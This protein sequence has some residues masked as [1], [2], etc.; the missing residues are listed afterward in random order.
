[1]EANVA[2]AVLPLSTFRIGGGDPEQRLAVAPACHVGVV[3]FEFESEK[4][5]QLPVKL[6]RAREI[7]DAQNQMVDADDGGHKT[8]PTA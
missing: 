1:M 5:Q 8:L 4:A 2:L 3:V 7:A 6:L